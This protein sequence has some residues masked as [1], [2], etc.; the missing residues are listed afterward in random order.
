MQ[1]NLSN[2]EYIYPSAVEP[3]LCKVT[4]TLSEGWTGFVG[5]NGSGKTTL[6]R[7]VCGLLQPDVGVVSPSLFSTYCAQ[8]AN[9]SPSN[10]FDFAVAYDDL[11]IR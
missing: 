4:A 6:A 2:I 10:L 7:I 5:D 1:L 8:S 3:T 11:A 9:E